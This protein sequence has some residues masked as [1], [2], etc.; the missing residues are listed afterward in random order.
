[1]R[2]DIEGRAAEIPFAA[3][4]RAKLVLTDDLLAAFA[5]ANG[6]DTADVACPS[7]YTT[8]R[9]NMNESLSGQRL[10]LC[11]KYATT[12]SYYSGLFIHQREIFQQDGWKENVCNP[13]GGLNGTTAWD[14][15][16]WYPVPDLNG[17]E[18]DLNAGVTSFTITP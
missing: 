7:G 12:G 9:W 6:A 1:M 4:E 2:L 8:K 3:I 11:V 18:S 14:A 15:L 17:G 10:Y 13:L 16:F 5:K